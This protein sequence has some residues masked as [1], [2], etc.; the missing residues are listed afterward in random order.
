MGG[1]FLAIL[2]NSY[3]DGFDVGPCGIDRNC[4]P[5]VLLCRDIALANADRTCGHLKPGFS[6]KS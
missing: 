4:P 5:Q 6:E 1:F 2:R 3:R